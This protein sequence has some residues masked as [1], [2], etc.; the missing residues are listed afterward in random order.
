MTFVKT[1]FV[2]WRKQNLH[3]V[4]IQ[5]FLDSVTDIWHQISIT[6]SRYNAYLISICFIC[7]LMFTSWTVAKSH[8][9]VSSFNAVIVSSRISEH[10]AFSL[11]ISST[12]LMSHQISRGEHSLFRYTISFAG[13]L[14]FLNRDRCSCS[15]CWWAWWGAC[16]RASS[17]AHVFWS[18][19]KAMA[20][21][22]SNFVKIRITGTENC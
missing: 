4:I 21:W 17:N 10:S 18:L 5:G 15:K 6:S 9:K 14:R 16:T 20:S 19:Q 2:Y 13:Y 7:N 22:L 3:Y 1:N 12:A 11:S 8:F